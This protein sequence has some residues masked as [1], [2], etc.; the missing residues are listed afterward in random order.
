MRSSLSQF[1]SHLHDSKAVRSGAGTPQVPCTAVRSG[2][3][4]PQVPCTAVR[5]GTGTPQVPCTA[6]RSGTGT[7]QVPCTAVR[8]GA[9][10]GLLNLRFCVS[11]DVSLG[12]FLL[13]PACPIKEVTLWEGF[14]Y[15]MSGPKTMK[16]LQKTKSL[17]EVGSEPGTP[18]PKPNMLITIGHRFTPQ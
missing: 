4:T 5:S 10:I 18:G 12:V 13:A 17:P 8:S 2:A 9:E 1:S 7:P 3:G 14:L 16:V 15:L 11:Q 6:V